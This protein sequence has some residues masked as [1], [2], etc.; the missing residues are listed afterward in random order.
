LQAQDRHVLP[1]L[2]PLVYCA[3][4]IASGLSGTYFSAFGADGFGWGVLAGSVLGPF[5][6]PLYGCLRSRMRWY[7]LLSFRNPD[8]RRDLL[9]SL[10]IM[11]GF[12]IVAVDAARWLEPEAPAR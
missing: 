8:L 4:I 9:L 3:A 10:P 5:A 1:A 7:P 6:L 11:I 2:A 12:L